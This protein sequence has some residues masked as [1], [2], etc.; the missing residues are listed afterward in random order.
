MAVWLGAEGISSWQQRETE[1]AL[2][3]QAKE[4]RQGRIF[5]VI[6]VLLPEVIDPALGFLGLN[7]WVDFWGGLG[8]ERSL[9]ALIHALDDELPGP[10][11]EQPADPRNAICPYRGLLS[12][13]E[14][15]AVFFV[16]A[17]PSRRSSSRQPAAKTG[18]DNQWN[19]NLR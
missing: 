14:E 1:R 12:F 8:D 10:P 17:R 9:K 5:P 4:E 2:D 11:G 3:R 19:G 18:S 7:T 16:D 15:D 13:R 6:P